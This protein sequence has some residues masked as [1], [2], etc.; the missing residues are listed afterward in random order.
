MRPISFSRALTPERRAGSAGK[1][2]VVVIS[3]DK[4]KIK[5][6]HFW[7]SFNYV[8][9]LFSGFVSAIRGHPPP[10]NLGSATTATTTIL[11]FDYRVHD[12][13]NND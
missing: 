9:L 4:Y 13:Y 2:V 12:V 7:W 3:D 10:N 6:L 8:G 5:K 11:K 1:E